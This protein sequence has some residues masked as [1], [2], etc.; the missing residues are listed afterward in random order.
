MVC[1]CMYIWYSFNQGLFI[2]FAILFSFNVILE[3]VTLLARK[4]IARFK[5]NT[6][7]KLIYDNTIISVFF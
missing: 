2:D 5:N 3:T 1:F 6:K 4:C 7:P